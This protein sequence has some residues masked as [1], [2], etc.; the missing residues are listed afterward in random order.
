MAVLFFSVRRTLLTKQAAD[1]SS[2]KI[3]DGT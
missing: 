3:R 2:V 1:I